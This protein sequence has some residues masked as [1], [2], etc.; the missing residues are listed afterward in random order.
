MRREFCIEHGGPSGGNGGN[1]GSIFLKCDSALNTLASLRRRVHYS[2][3]SGISGK[4]DS[5]HGRNGQDIELSV[6]I[7]YHPRSII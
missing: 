7:K 3:T 1:G 6:R 5:R 4:G 2:A